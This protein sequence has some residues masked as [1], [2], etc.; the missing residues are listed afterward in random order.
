MQAGSN[1]RNVLQGKRDI[2]LPSPVFEG[3]GEILHMPKPVRSSR[4]EKVREQYLTTHHECAGCGQRDN[5]EVHHKL[6]FHLFPDKE[7]DPSNLMTL[8]TEGPGRINCHLVIGHLGDWTAY[9][10]DAEF[11]AWSF[12]TSVKRRRK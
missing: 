1:V 6:P 8:C 3:G 5:L 9:N 12:L 2:H 11:L 10:P 4:W 7:L